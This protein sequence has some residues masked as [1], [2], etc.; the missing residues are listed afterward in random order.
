MIEDKFYVILFINKLVYIH[1][2]ASCGDYGA[3]QWHEYWPNERPGRF[4]SV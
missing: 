2:E 3:G 4:W 1:I